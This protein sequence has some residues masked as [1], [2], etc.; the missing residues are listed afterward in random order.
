MKEEKL[1]QLIPGMVHVGSQTAVSCIKTG[2]I[3]G[4]FIIYGIMYM[5]DENKS[6]LMKL[7]LVLKGL[8]KLEL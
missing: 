3:I 5:P 1:P 6:R 8:A 4:S 7:N 2:S